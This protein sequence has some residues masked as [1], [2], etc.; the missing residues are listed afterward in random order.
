V[1]LDIGC[2][3]QKGNKPYKKGSDPLI[4]YADIVKT[5]FNKPFLSICC[6][7]LNLPFKDNSFSR[8]LA[9]HVLEHVYN[10]LKFLKECKRV[11]K[12]TIIIAIPHLLRDLRFKNESESH[13]FTWSYSSFQHLLKLVFEDFIIQRTIIE[14]QFP[15][16]KKTINQILNWIVLFFSRSRRENELI[17]YCH[18]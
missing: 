6:S 3:S 10:P 18:A 14:P 5:E 8:V 16:L 4:V 11:A 12:R 13:I 2:G 15:F 7:G 1:N 9:F 17:A